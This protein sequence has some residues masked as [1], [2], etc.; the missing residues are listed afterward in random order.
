MR[1]YT[2]ASVTMV[3]NKEENRRTAALE[4][5]KRAIVLNAEASNTTHHER[6]AVVTRELD[7]SPN[8]TEIACGVISSGNDPTMAHVSNA[9]IG[10]SG[11]AITNFLHCELRERGYYTQ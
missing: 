6:P 2:V 3:L 11:R 7:N 8:T 10:M 1:K 5:A 9:S 4:Y